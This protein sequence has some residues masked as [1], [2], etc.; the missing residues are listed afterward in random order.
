MRKHRGNK[1]PAWGAQITSWVAAVV[2]IP[3]CWVFRIVLLVP[4]M[5]AVTQVAVPQDVVVWWCCT[6]AGNQICSSWHSSKPTDAL[7]LFYVV[8]F[9][10]ETLGSI[11]FPICC[12]QILSL[13]MWWNWWIGCRTH[14]RHWRLQHWVVD[15]CVCVCVRGWK[16]GKL[17]GKRLGC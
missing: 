14:Q 2:R 4:K 16:S 10:K 17:C 3:L 8:F 6:A 11:F 13:L 5:T 7:L 1:C 15:G 9:L 12:S